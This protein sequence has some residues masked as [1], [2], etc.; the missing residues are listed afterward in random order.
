MQKIV[1]NLWFDK[2][3]REAAEFYCSVFPR[4]KVNDVVT[5]YDTPS[6]DVD[7]VNFELDGTSF[8]AI[9]G[10]P[11]FKFNPSLS[12]IVNVDPSKDRKADKNI[13]R[14]W[15]MLSEDGKELMP[16]QEYP[17]SKKY[18]WV[19]DRYG[20]SWQLILSDPVGNERPF[21][22]PSL[23]FVGEKAG[24]AEEAINFYLSIFNNSKIGTINRYPPGMDPER[25]GSIQFS[26]F[27]LEG[28]WLS[29]MD[30]SGP[31]DFD[32]NEAI[33]FMIY[34]EDQT[35]IDYFWQ[36]LSAVPDSEQCGWLKD[37][38]GISWQVV[39]KIL[40][41]LLSSGNRDQID[42]L[43]QAFLPMKKLIIEDIKK[44]YDE[45]GQ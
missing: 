27:M 7:V 24:R 39:P 43:T 25:Q 14:F 32:F 21:I 23:L 35:E 26:D 4:S 19:E 1:P 5:L 10:G 18:G 13:V 31:H 38:Y 22:V 2:S 3:A 8:T 33:S 36:R 30:S 17:F 37:R 29:A 9:N 41:Q 20:V 16:F 42:S 11:A 34:C 45:A 15:A 28:V 12:F 40:P 6:G 44:A